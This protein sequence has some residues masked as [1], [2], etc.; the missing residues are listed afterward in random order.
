MQLNKSLLSAHA[1][2]LARASPRNLYCMVGNV[3][4]RALTSC[5]AS[6]RVGVVIVDHGS[7][8]KESN[9]QL[10][11]FGR[12][13]QDMTEASIVEIAHMEIAE[14]T[15]E[16]AIEKCVSQGANHVV[17]AP[18][19][20]SRGRHIQEDIP[21]LVNAAKLR[22]PSL[23]CEIAEPIGIDPLMAQLIK[24]RVDSVLETSAQLRELEIV[25]NGSADQEH[26]GQ[27]LRN[28]C[29]SLQLREPEIVPYGSADQQHSGQFLGNSCRSQQL[30]GLEIVPYDSADQ[31]HSEQCLDNSCSS[32]KLMEL[33][34]VPYGSADQQH[35]G[36]FLGNSCSS[37]QLMELEIAP[38]GSADQQH[39]G[40]FLGNS[41]S[42]QQLRELEIVPCDSADKD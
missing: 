2:R 40:Q 24:N 26:N 22:F 8:K 27:C 15:I 34:I 14:P 36:Q 1:H 32:Q 7:R 6:K 4:H 31:Q 38:Y 41:C 9:E 39:S 30:R 3:G 18:Y 28:F 23:E 10:V 12:L 13:Y 21:E 17:I 33:Q 42:S 35:S 29:S 5:R 16:Q 25:S 11:E 19:F 20:L 37:Q